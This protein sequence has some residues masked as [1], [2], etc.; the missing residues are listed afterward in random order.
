MTADEQNARV[1]KLHQHRPRPPVHGTAALDPRDAADDSLPLVVD[2]AAI[3]QDGPPP[4]DPGAEP[5]RL[6]TLRLG[7]RWARSRKRARGR[8]HQEPLTADQLAALDR[9]RFKRARRYAAMRRTAYSQVRR[10]G[11]GGVV[12][13]RGTVRGVAHFVWQ[14]ELG[15]LYRAMDDSNARARNMAELYRSRLV[16]TGLLLGGAGGV[17]LAAPW[18]ADWAAGGEDGR[19]LWQWLLVAAV[20]TGGAWV[21]GRIAEAEEQQQALDDQLPPGLVAGMGSR[22]VETNFRLAFEA[23]KIEGQVQ[24]A[25]V[26]G[27]W[28]WIVTTDILSDFGRAELDRLARRLDT[29]RGGLLV[30]SPRESSR[31]RVFTVVLADLLASG[32]AAVRHPD[33]PLSVPRVLAK[34]FDGGELAIPL[35]GLHI[36]VF[37]RTGSGKSTVLKGFIDA[38]ASARAVIGAIDMTG[39]FDLRA[40]EAV[41]DPRLCAFGDDAAATMLVLERVKAIAMSR[42]ERTPAGSKW[43]STRQDPPIRLVIDEYGVVAA[44]SALREL[45]N[46]IILYGRNVDCHLLFGSHR[47]VADIMGDGTVGSQVQCKVY[48]AMDA[49][50]VRTLPKAVRDQGVA[51]ERLVPANAEQ[52][53]DASKGYVVGLQDPAPLV[54]FNSYEAGEDRRRADAYAQAGLG[55]LSAAD[56]EAMIALQNAQQDVPELLKCVQAAITHVS[57]DGRKPAKATTEEIVSYLQVKGHRDITVQNLTA[58]MRQEFGPA[59]PEGRRQDTN[60]HGRNQKGWYLEDLN[61]ALDVLAELRRR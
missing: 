49:D 8:V 3:P 38:F 19:P 10:T 17:W 29:P 42:K 41:F 32:Q 12:L 36:A 60:L 34:R 48:L 5:R 44:N 18:L 9:A 33:L 47:K 27:N 20:L 23:L 4:A 53:N 7:Y 54:R 21:C 30:S 1:F 11:R 14:P 22:A 40:W 43:V 31:A 16:R 25:H 57:F 28:G 6:E 61:N 55:Q 46:W 13:V 59:F 26:G 39:G 15:A 45:V 37:G 51:P 50:D 56:V 24:V 35:A 58:R 2:G 52:V